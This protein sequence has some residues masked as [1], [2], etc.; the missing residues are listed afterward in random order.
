MLKEGKPMAGPL[1][2]SPPPEPSPDGLEGAAREMVDLEFLYL[3]Q[4]RAVYTY[5]RSKTGLDQTSADDIMHTAFLNVGRRMRA[6]LE[7]EDWVPYL[8]KAAR[9]VGIDWIRAQEKPG[10]I[11]E[12]GQE[13]A[14]PD[15]EE[16]YERVLRRVD[17]QRTIDAAMKALGELTPRQCEAVVLHEMCNL[18]PHRSLRLSESKKAL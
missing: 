11:S 4:A 3:T 14:D 2:G 8:F 13:F 10:L 18:S 5:V 17:H 12:K 15:S 16:P 7:A 1:R 9:N 6:G